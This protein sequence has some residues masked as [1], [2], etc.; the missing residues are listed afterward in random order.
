MQIIYIYQQELI[1]SDLQSI[2]NYWLLSMK[3][4]VT[5]YTCVNSLIVEDTTTDVNFYN[6]TTALWWEKLSRK[7]VMLKLPYKAETVA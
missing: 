1:Q 5:T 6:K 7:K 2:F 4:T 3:E